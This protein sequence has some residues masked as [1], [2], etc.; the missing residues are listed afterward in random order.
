MAAAAVLKF[1]F[2]NVHIFFTKHGRNMNEVCF[3]MFSNMRN[4]M[5]YSEVQYNEHTL[6]KIEIVEINV[7][8]FVLEC[9]ILQAGNN[10]YLYFSITHTNKNNPL[11]LIT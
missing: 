11:G 9:T 5:L 6:Q 7:M 4:P 10:N 3:C 2:V 8:F 1:K